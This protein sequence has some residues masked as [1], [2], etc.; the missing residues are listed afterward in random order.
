MGESEA[1]TSLPTERWTLESVELY[2]KLTDDLIERGNGD[3]VKHKTSLY[4]DES[5][6]FIKAVMSEFPGKFFEYQY[7]YNTKEQSLKGVVQFGPYAQ[8]PPG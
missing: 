6:L 8:G 3:W 7:F 1:D 2:K 4:N 5:R